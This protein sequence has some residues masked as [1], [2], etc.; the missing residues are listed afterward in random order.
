MCLIVGD[1]VFYEVLKLFY[2]KEV[3]DVD[4]RVDGCLLRI[5]GSRIW[6]EIWRKCLGM[7]GV[8]EKALFIRFLEGE[9]MNFDRI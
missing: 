1:V 2:N 4:G 3:F 5:L 6:V 8:R 7:R 9:G